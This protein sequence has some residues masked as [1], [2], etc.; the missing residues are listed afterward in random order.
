ME[1]AWDGGG[2]ALEEG[3]MRS[4]VNGMKGAWGVGCSVWGM[5]GVG[6]MDADLRVQG[7]KYA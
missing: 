5:K 2:S 3:C 6:C 1:G 4:R 7:M